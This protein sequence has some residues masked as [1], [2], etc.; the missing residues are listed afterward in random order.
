MPIIPG[1]FWKWSLL[2]Y[3]I[4][5]K[6]IYI[7]Y[8]FLIWFKNVALLFPFYVLLPNLNTFLH[9]NS[10]KSFS[11]SKRLSFTLI[12][13]FFVYCFS[14]LPQY[15]HFYRF[16]ISYDSSLDSAKKKIQNFWE[17]SW[18]EFIKQESNINMTKQIFES[19]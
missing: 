18:L 13:L 1:V 15:V 3:F 17:K 19:T 7:I 11:N 2:C 16:D 5:F 9:F 6:S 12:I 8:R 4:F 14:I 10:L